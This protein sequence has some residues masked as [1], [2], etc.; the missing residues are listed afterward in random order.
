MLLVIG[1]LSIYWFRESKI[2]STSA[3]GT[4]LNTG[5]R[6]RY[7]EVVRSSIQELTSV[8]GTVLNTGVRDRYREVVESSIYLLVRLNATVVQAVRPSAERLN[9][10]L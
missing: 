10:L 4:E 8:S 6:G 2:E 9:A 5:A 1:Q 7:R 3:S